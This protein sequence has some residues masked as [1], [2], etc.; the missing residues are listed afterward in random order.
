MKEHLG[1]QNAKNG[2]NL[3]FQRRNSFQPKLLKWKTIVI[4]SH[5]FNEAAGPYKKTRTFEAVVV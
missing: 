1:F 3:F 2:R 4:E 5:Y